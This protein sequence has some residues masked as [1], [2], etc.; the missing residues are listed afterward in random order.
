MTGKS[1]CNDFSV[2]RK[3]EHLK[4]GYRNPKDLFGLKSP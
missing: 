2:K 1:L 3:A 4:H